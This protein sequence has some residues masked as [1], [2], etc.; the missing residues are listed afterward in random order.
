MDVVEAVPAAPAPLARIADRVRA[1]FIARRAQ[2]AAN[3]AATRILAAVARGTPLPQ[4]IA[5][6]GQTGVRPPEPV[7]IRRGALLQFAQQGQEVPPPL[8]ILFTLQPGKAQRA[9]GPS[10]IYLVKL[11]RVVPGN[12][13]ANPQL[14]AGEVTGLQRAAGEELALQWLAAAQKE[15]GVTR[16][17]DAIRAAR[18]RIIGGQS[19]N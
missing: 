10:G 9:A 17:E 16:N 19:A 6:Q 8:R 2:E 18:S 3:A 4:A 14:I 5:A 13:G 1:D 15:L 7:D 12:A 11:D